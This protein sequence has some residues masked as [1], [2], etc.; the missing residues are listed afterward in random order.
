MIRLTFKHPRFRALLEGNGITNE[1]LY[2][3]LNVTPATVSRWR[4]GYAPPLPVLVKI[5]A[6]CGQ[7]PADIADLRIGDYWEVA[8]GESDDET[9][10]VQ[11]G[12]TYTVRANAG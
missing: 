2:T 12:I 5:L 3:T 9:E 10:F 4:R 6:M 7:T 1:M 11:A 8:P